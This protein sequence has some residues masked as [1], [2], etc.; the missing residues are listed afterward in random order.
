MT[1]SKVSRKLAILR[2][3]LTSIYKNEGYATQS[4]SKIDSPLY[5]TGENNLLP[6]QTINSDQNKEALASA[7][8]MMSLLSPPT[9]TQLVQIS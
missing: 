2:A 1:Q 4:K 5:G 6:S 3:S 8:T 7:A 9:T